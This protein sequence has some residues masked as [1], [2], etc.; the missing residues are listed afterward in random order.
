MIILAF[1]REV[2][3]QVHRLLLQRDVRQ[4]D[5][6]TLVVSDPQETGLR[7]V[8]SQIMR[9]RC[10]FEVE[11][12]QDHGREFARKTCRAVYHQSDSLFAAS[13]SL[14]IGSAPNVFSHPAWGL[15]SVVDMFRVA[16]SSSTSPPA[17]L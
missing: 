1:C 14:T 5:S 10:Q 11:S 17:L 9:R 2:A 16:V 3:Q 8:G 7:A 15:Q 4:A 6:M 12:G 13:V